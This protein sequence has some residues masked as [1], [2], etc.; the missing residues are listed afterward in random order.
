MAKLG[1]LYLQ[2]GMWQGEQILPAA[3][4]ES[5]VTPRGAASRWTDYGYSWWLYNEAAARDYLDGHNDIYYALG[6][7]GQFVWVLPY[8]NTVIACTGWNDNNGRWPESML[9]DFLG[10]AIDR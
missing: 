1:Q 6:R 7:G 8:A 4:V 9:W 3:W 2:R 10:P 5:S